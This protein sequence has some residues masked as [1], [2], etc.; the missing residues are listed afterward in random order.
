MFYSI[1]IGIN[2]TLID[3]GSFELS[4]HGLFTFVAVATAVVL[5][6]GMHL[7]VPVPTLQR[8]MKHWR[9]QWTWVTVLRVTGWGRREG[10]VADTVYSVA[11][12]G[13]IGGIV[14][15]RLVHV[16]DRW[17]FY[18]NNLGQAIAFWQPGV[19]IYGAIIG[20]FLGGAIY[21][22]V[23]HYR[24]QMKDVSAGRLA[25]LT[26]PAVL[27]AQAIGRIGDVINGEHVAKVTDLAWGF[28]YTNPSSGS[29]VQHG[30]IPSHPAVV[31]EMILDMA[32]LAVV[33]KLRGRLKPPG[34]LFAVY[35]ML[36]SLGRFFIQFLRFDKEW[37]AGLNEAQ[38]ISLIV[39]AITV[40]LVASR[41][42][43][44]QREEAPPPSK[45]PRRARRSRA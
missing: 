10:I 41:A 25:D 20:G 21:I 45:R 11:V 12:W 36:Y 14:G 22:W 30:V 40:P 16:I 3:I 43:W 8:V 37:V 35:A 6:A 42:K 29:Y 17:D 19:A 13:I 4:W 26:A 15:A 44:V 7:R 5:L 34:M 1:S 39:L 2:P 27:I 38:I 24:G 31:Y 9:L 32:V 28:V 18:S 23:N 33:W